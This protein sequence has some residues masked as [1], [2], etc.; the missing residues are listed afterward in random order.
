[1]R[2]TISGANKEEGR[3]LTDQIESEVLQ[4]IGEL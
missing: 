4:G 1:L 2:S 3:R